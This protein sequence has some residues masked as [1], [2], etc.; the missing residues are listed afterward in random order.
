MILILERDETPLLDDI[1]NSKVILKKAEGRLYSVEHD[2]RTCN[3]PK[4]VKF[5]DVMEYL[6]GSP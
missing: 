4:Y 1:R 3:T 2:R 6:E 5:E